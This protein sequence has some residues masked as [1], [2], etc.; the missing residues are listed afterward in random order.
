VN[1]TAGAVAYD[2]RHG[3]H[4]EEIAMHENVPRKRRRFKQEFAL[5]VRLE[6][7]AQQCRAM[8]QQRSGQERDSLLQTARRYELTAHLDEWLSSP[9]LQPPR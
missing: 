6:R 9:G 1:A 4:S 7:A 2:Q 5:K 8:A 3:T